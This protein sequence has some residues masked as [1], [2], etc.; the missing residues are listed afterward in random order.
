MIQIKKTKGVEMA[1]SEYGVDI[2]IILHNSGVMGVGKSERFITIPMKSVF[3][4]KRGLESYIQ[5][6]Y[7]KSSKHKKEN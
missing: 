3:Q 4:V 2:K 6:F 1:G 5:K 7:R